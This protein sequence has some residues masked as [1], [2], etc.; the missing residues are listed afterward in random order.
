[1]P[2]RVRRHERRHAASS[3]RV[4]QGRCG[5][6]A[7]GHRPDRRPGGRLDRW[8]RMGPARALPPELTPP[9]PTSTTLSTAKVLAWRAGGAAVEVVPH[10]DARSFMKIS[11]VKNMA[12]LWQR[13]IPIQSLKQLVGYVCISLLV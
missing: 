5:R 9:L 4:G 2:R 8:N 11:P 10:F 3:P 13:L 7:H 6:A 1:M 12:P